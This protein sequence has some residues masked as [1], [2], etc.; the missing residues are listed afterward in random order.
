MTKSRRD[1][2]N[3]PQQM[4]ADHLRVSAASLSRYESGKRKWP[5]LLLKR[6]CDFLGMSSP[7]FSELYWSWKRHR[8]EWNWP[9]YTVEVEPGSTWES[10][11]NGYED[12][13][14][15]RRFTRQ[16]PPEIKRLLRADSLLEVVPYAEFYHDGAETVFASI[17]AL[18]PPPVFLIKESGVPLGLARRAAIRYK[19]WLHFPQITFLIGSRRIR[20]DVLAYRK[21]VW[22]VLEFDGGLH[23]QRTEYD[24]RRDAKL[25]LP[26][27]RFSEAEILSGR[28]TSIFA[29]RMARYE[30]RRAA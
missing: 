15:I 13:Y 7:E 9:S 24:M 19:G 11:G 5:P 30:G 14:E 29:E 10:L 16:P 12:F 22:V 1:E 2:L 21:G 23:G 8:A 17:I 26:V 4:L 3:I 25:K 6:A 27:E 28:F 20:V 18:N